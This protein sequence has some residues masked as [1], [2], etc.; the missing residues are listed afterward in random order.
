MWSERSASRPRRLTSQ[1]AGIDA[2]W[3][4]ASAE[5]W[6]IR[7]RLKI[8]E[9]LE[10]VWTLKSKLVFFFCFQNVTIISIITQPCT[11]LLSNYHSDQLCLA[12]NLRLSTE[13]VTASKSLSSRR[14]NRKSKQSLKFSW[15]IR[16]RFYR[17]DLLN[18]NEFRTKLSI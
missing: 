8:D 17:I 16:K 10:N 14:R 9:N 18:L 5:K 12:G 15:K 3:T 4:N 2:I 7:R 13:L 1:V 11:V 6:T